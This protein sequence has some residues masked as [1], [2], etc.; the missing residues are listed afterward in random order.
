MIVCKFSKKASVSE[1]P[2]PSIVIFDF[3]VKEPLKMPAL[4]LSIPFSGTESIAC[5]IEENFAIVME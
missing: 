3:T 4:S 1:N 2:L 5:W